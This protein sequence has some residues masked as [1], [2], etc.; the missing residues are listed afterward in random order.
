M[1]DITPGREKMLGIVIAAGASNGKGSASKAVDALIAASG[2]H[3]HIVHVRNRVW[4]VQHPIT[5]RFH[6]DLFE[7]RYIDLIQIAWGQGAFSDGTYNRVWL[8]RGV[9]MWEELP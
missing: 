4:T 7:C 1:A 3:D 6:G 9:L 2:G 5:E 8:D